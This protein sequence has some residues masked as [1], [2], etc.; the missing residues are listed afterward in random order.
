MFSGYCIRATSSADENLCGG[1]DGARFNDWDGDALQLVQNGVVIGTFGPGFVDEEIC[2]EE[3]QFNQS[4]DVFELRS[5][6]NDGVSVIA[7]AICN[8][9]NFL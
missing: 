9:C 6:G 2:I 8:T 1:R 3:H 5:T 7:I 4:N